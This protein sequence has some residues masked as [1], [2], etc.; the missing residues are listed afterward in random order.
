[1][2][3]CGEVTRQKQDNLNDNCSCRTT[4]W[5]DL[6]VPA[7]WSAPHRFKPV[8]NLYAFFINLQMLLFMKPDSD[9]SPP[10]W[11]LCHI[12]MVVVIRY[13]QLIIPVHQS[14]P[15]FSSCPR[16]CN[17]SHINIACNTCRFPSA[18]PHFPLWVVFIEK[19]S[20]GCV[21]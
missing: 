1:M 11:S 20:L 21:S 3:V 16:L 19:N 9:V 5:I 14:G 10:A 7:L 17:L 6:F 18:V 15:L 12:L 13:G 8:I 4:S 2:N